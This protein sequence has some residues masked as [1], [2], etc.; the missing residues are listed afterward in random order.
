MQYYLDNQSINR[1]TAMV[2]LRHDPYNPQSNIC[3][4]YH[5][6]SSGY[7][8]RLPFP[9][10]RVP[11]EWVALWQT[12]EEVTTSIVSAFNTGI[13]LAIYDGHGLVGEWRRPEFTTDHVA[14]LEQNNRL[15]FVYSGACLVG[16]Y[17][18]YYYLTRCLI[19]ALLQ[20]PNA[21][22]VGCIANA[23]EMSV[24]NG[25]L[26]FQGL[27]TAFYPDFDSVH[28]GDNAVKFYRPGEAIYF[29]RVYS[30]TYHEQRLWEYLNRIHQFFGDPEMMIRAA[31]PH[32]PKWFCRM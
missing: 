12:E 27:M 30:E 22:A 1:F 10:D 6:H 3:D 19:E 4:T 17:N 9:Q 32:T 7:P 11:D 13:G 31:C 8:N 15:S 29:S 20:K 26:L 14:D 16:K 23:N 28:S 25:A 21:G 2:N 24:K 5:F 18:D